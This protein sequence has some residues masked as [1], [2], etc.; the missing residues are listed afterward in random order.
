MTEDGMVNQNKSYLMESLEEATRLE[1]KTDPKALKT[2][3]L[4]C[5]IRPGLRV[6]DAGFGSG[7][8]ASILH[9][10]IQPGGYVL[11]VDSSEE[12]TS[13]A[14]QQ[15][16]QKSGIEFLVHD[17]RDPLKGLD[18]FDLIWVR[19]FLEYHR[20]ESLDIIKNLTESLKPGGYLCL[21]DLDHN[22]LNHYEMPVKMEKMLKEIMIK[23]EQ[24]YNFDPY[25]GRKLY[26]FLYDL[27]FENIEVDL[28]AHHLIFGEVQEKDAFN[29]L[30]K[31]EVITK[32]TKTLFKNYPGGHK[33]FHKDFAEYF[34][35]PR[36]FIYTPMILCKGMKPL[37]D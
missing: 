33:G 16:G 30:K 4:W 15:Y 12:R 19:F 3:A 13:F 2:Q 24:E 6:M 27:G 32:K 14:K 28:T 34:Y 18:Q 8:T 9:E 10:M 35:N 5:G 11:G 17:L 21:L 20:K 23:L 25:A 7:K 22:C 36:R 26:S 31:E 29:W 1:M 37:A